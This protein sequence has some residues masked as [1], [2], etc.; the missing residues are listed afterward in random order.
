[1]NALEFIEY[2]KTGAWKKSR[3]SDIYP[4]KTGKCNICTCRHFVDG[5]GYS[6]YMKQCEYKG[7]LVFTNVDLKAEPEEPHIQYWADRFHEVIE[8]HKHPIQLT[9]NFE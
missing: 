4:C 7:Y 2:E 3:K 1:M 5:F 6:C 9:I 8:R